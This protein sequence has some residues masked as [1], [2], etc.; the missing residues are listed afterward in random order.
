MLP[1]SVEL[2][3]VAA[4]WSGVYVHVPFCARICPYCDFNVV[5]DRDSL[6]E[7][8]ER[9]VRSEILA[10][11]AWRPIAAV[12]FGGGTPSR[13]HAQ[14]LNAILEAVGARFGLVEG[15]EVSLE[16]NPEDWTPDLAE[17]LIGGGFN[18]VSFGAQSF[19]PVVLG[20]LGRLHEPGDVEQGVADARRAGFKSVSLDL[21]FGTPG[22][23]IASWQATVEQAIALDPDHLS[24]YALTVERGTALSRS[25]AAGAPSPDEDDQADKYEM[26][27][28]L[29]A[30]AGY[31]RYEVSNFARPGHACRYNLLTWAQAE[32]LGFGPGAHGHRSGARYRT[33]HRLEAYLEAVEAGR[34]PEQGRD[35]S[36]SWHREQERL[37]L[38]LR[39]AAGVV[40]GCGGEALENDEWGQRLFAA[41]IVVRRGERIVIDQ[42]L[43]GDEVVRAVLALPP[44][45]C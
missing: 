22:E 43:L 10:E 7:R 28:A 36:D 8:Y 16:A 20:A 42:P 40:A 41:G 17:A 26:A 3:E 33:I 4:E 44:V 23:S 34:R 2:A 31:L 32:Y 35:R 27:Q 38:G 39:R 14:A 9:A 45:E 1:D 6:Q 30:A 25:I 11:D 15:A 5:A 19:D 18:R 24:L 37:M 29:L 13:L 21:I 12:A